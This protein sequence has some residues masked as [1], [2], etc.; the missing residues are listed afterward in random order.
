MLNLRRAISRTLLPVVVLAAVLPL[1]LLAQDHVVTEGDLR[2]EIR[3]SAGEREANVA[4]IQQFLSS[5]AAQQALR[6]MK[7]DPARIQNAVPLLSAE[8]L[9]SLAAR[10]DHENFAA[11]G[12]TLT[13]TQVTYL[14]IAIAVVV[15][16]AILA[17]R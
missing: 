14:I 16:V 5:D 10:V 17:T 2:A 3:N 13:N 1:D 9:A 15:I 12:L 7:L 11:G 6:S 4:K 8:E